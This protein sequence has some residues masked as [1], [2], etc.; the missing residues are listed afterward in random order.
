VAHSPASQYGKQL[1]ALVLGDIKA[2]KEIKGAKPVRVGSGK[3]NGILIDIE[4]VKATSGK[5]E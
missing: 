1:T 5:P 3:K 2:T 4:C